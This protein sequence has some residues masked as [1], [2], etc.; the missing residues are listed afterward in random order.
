MWCTLSCSDPFHLYLYA[1]VLE[2]YQV[3]VLHPTLAE[4][5]D[6]DILWVHWLEVDWKHQA[7]WKVKRLYHIR[8]VPSHEEGAFGFLDLKDVICGVHLIPGFNNGYIICSPKDPISKWDYAQAK[9]WKTYYVNQWVYSLWS[10]ME[11]WT[12]THSP[13]GQ[14]CWPWHVHALPR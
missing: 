2:I 4:M 12:H 1:W 11:L 6:M 13:R 8:F 14:V 7:G 9:N 10:C 3:K 5:T